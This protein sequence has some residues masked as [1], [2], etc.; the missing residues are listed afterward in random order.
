M[1]SDKPVHCFFPSW[2][3]GRIRII[4]GRINPTAAGSST[5]QMPSGLFH[6]KAST[7][8]EA[9]MQMKYSHFPSSTR[10]IHLGSKDV[11]FI[12]IATLSKSHDGRNTCK[13]HRVSDIGYNSSA[14]DDTRVFALHIQPSPSHHVPKFLRNPQRDLHRLPGRL[15]S[16]ILSSSHAFFFKARDSPMPIP[17]R[18]HSRIVAPR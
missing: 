5:R 12:L 7:E 16:P 4:V 6:I 10:S 13:I 14:L 17:A 1:T 2:W 11:V 18:K 9:I 15:F 3:R 8:T